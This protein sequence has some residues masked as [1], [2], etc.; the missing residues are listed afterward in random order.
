MYEVREITGLYS[1]P[2]VPKIKAAERRKLSNTL[3]EI[4]KVRH[5]GIPIDDIESTLNKIGYHMIQEDGTPWSGIFC[6]SEGNCYIQIAN[7]D[8]NVPK[9][10]ICLS[11]YNQYITYEINV[12][13]S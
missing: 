3:Y 5:T 7:E 8:G 1:T 6:G 13:L 9:N 12:Y 11:W 10:L 2:F 4:S